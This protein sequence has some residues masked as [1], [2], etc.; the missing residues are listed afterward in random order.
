MS[1]FSTSSP[2]EE[3]GS[4][5]EREA[6]ISA[7]ISYLGVSTI[8]E[9][10]WV[11]RALER[12][13]QEKHLDSANKDVNIYEKKK[14]EIE[15]LL[16]DH[17]SMIS[18]IANL[19][20]EK[21]SVQKQ[22][23]GLKTDL[24]TLSSEKEEIIFERDLLTEELQRIGRLYEGLTG[25]QASQEDLKGVL[26]IYITLMED[27]FSGR[28]HFKVLSIIHG[29]KETWKRNELVKSSGISEIKLRSVL[30]D[31]VRANMIVYDEEKASVKLIKR[32]SALD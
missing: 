22:M 2:E 25:K 24:Y 3:M 31:L 6:H 26:N 19:Q 32:L 17:Q 4:L 11:Q 7:I 18:N 30:G 1:F 10:I 8:G 14:Q 12:N 5:E 21:E 27:V 16:N 9:L 13:F 29:E 28:A 23:E 20:D 15:K